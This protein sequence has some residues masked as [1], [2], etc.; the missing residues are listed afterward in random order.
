MISNLN[1]DVRMGILAVDLVEK[2]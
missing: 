1:N 2:V